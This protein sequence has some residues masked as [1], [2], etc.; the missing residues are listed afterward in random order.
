MVSAESLTPTCQAQVAEVKTP[1]LKKFLHTIHGN[2]DRTG[3][4]Q[5]EE[6]GYTQD[7]VTYV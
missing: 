5:S 1:L 4:H 3:R 6:E 2:M 7:E